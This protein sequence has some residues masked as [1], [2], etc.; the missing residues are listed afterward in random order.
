MRALG[1]RR[2]ATAVKVGV[3]R[4][5]FDLYD[6]ALVSLTARH[7]AALTSAIRAGDDELGGW[8]LLPVAVLA[9]AAVVIG[10]V[11]PRLWEFH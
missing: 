3:L 7:Q 6:A 5:D 9:L 10:G 8:S 1:S 4:S 11:A 2:D